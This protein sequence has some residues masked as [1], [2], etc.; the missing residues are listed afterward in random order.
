MYHLFSS[1]QAET[2]GTRP[3][4]WASPGARRGESLPIRG[5]YTCH[6]RCLTRGVEYSCS[7]WEAATSYMLLRPSSFSKIFLWIFNKNQASIQV[8]LVVS[9]YNL[10]LSPHPKL[11]PLTTLCWKC[12]IP[13]FQP[14]PTL[15]APCSCAQTT[16]LLSHTPVAQHSQHSTTSQD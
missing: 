10:D 1:L 5:D 8:V 7:N 9:A 12:Q 2:L 4:D 14:A 11:S 15:I 6:Q 16:R 13:R 3:W